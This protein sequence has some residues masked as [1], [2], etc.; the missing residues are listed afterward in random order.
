MR[1]FGIDA[2]KAINSAR[3]IGRGSSARAIRGPF[4]RRPDQNRNLLCGTSM[5]IDRSDRVHMPGRWLLLRAMPSSAVL[6]RSRSRAAGSNPEP[7]SCSASRRPSRAGAG[8]HRAPASRRAGD[9]PGPS[10]SG[11]SRSAADL[12][13]LDCDGAHAMLA[14]GGERHGRDLAALGVAGPA[15]VAWRAGHGSPTPQNP[16]RRPIRAGFQQAAGTWERGLCGEPKP[17]SG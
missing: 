13:A 2:P 1:L 3:R 17:S 4:G 15:R 8:R 5:P 9:P 14:H 7:S 12:L 10:P 6:G 16:A 11:H